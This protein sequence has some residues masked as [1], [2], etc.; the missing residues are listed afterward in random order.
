MTDAAK[1]RRPYWA[2]DGSHPNAAQ[3]EDEHR[4][5]A[6][7]VTAETR[8]TNETGGQKGSKPQQVHQIPVDFLLG[9]GQVYAVS[10]ADKYPDAAPGMPNWALG[11]DWSLCYSSLHRHLGAFW[12]GEFIDPDDGLPHLLK[13]AWHCATLFTWHEEGIA[14]ECDDR[15]K[16]LRGVEA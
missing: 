7:L 11:Y 14:P 16:Y 12:K 5:I 13:A 3:Q 4:R 1:E 9:L 2:D 10:Q 8:V 15:P 6:S